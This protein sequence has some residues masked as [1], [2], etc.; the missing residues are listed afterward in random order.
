VHG[1]ANRA[2]LIG[3]GPVDGLPDPPGGIGAELEA[4]FVIELVHRAQQAQVTF[5][6]EIEKG[7]RAPRKAFG[8]ADHQPQIGLCHVPAS[9]IALHDLE[10]EQVAC[11]SIQLWSLGLQPLGG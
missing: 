3:D 4:F 10:L 5:L 2:P 8:H 1:D 11:L 6:D 9:Q 7:H